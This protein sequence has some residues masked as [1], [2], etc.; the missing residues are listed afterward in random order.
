MNKKLGI[1]SALGMAFALSLSTSAQALAPAA[2]SRIESVRRL[3]EGRS[4]RAPLGFLLF[5]MKQPSHCRNGGGS[6]RTQMTA[7]LMRVLN[8]VNRSVNRTI[9]PR[10]DRGDVWSINVASGDCED[11]VLTKRNKLIRMGV[12]AGSLRIATAK[13]RSGTGHAVLVV[14]TKQGDYVM[15]NRTSRIKEWHKTG[16]HWVAMSGSNPKKWHAV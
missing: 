13:T 3:D 11:Y 7:Q 12:P 1:I 2:N 16:L 4:T 5:C 15:D 10:R 6:G 9:R 8:S 14:R